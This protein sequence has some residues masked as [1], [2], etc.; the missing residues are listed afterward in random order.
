MIIQNM[1]C[2]VFQIVFP[3]IEQMD[4]EL[5][6]DAGMLSLLLSRV[7][8]SCL[9]SVTESSHLCMMT[10]YL[11]YLQSAHWTPSR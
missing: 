7:A 11:L 1:A 3:S 9:L 4:S 8:A 6:H 10:L 5:T 2:S